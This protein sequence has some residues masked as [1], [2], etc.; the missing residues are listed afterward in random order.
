[1][2]AKAVAASNSSILMCGIFGAEVLNIAFESQR[3]AGL[4]LAHQNSTGDVGHA[5]LVDGQVENVDAVA[6]G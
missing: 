6:F 4:E 1:M 2:S 5:R 3:V